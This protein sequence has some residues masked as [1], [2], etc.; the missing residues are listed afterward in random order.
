MSS[1]TLA[2]PSD[3]THT[4]PWR[5]AYHDLAG[6]VL[7][8]L[9]TRRHD[10]ARVR[11]HLGA[12]RSLI[13]AGGPGAGLA[14][15][16]ATLESLRLPHPHRVLRLDGGSRATPSSSMAGPLHSNVPTVYLVREDDLEPR[17]EAGPTQLDP[18]IASWRRGYLELVHLQPIPSQ[19]LERPIRQVTGAGVLNDLQVATIAMLA[20]GSPLIALDLALEAAEAPQHV[21]HQP[22]TAFT[23]SS[24]FGS[25]AAPRLRPRLDLLLQRPD[26][27]KLLSNIQDLARLGQVPESVAAMLVG[28]ADLALLSEFGV[29][30]H[31]GSGHDPYVAISHVN[32]VALRSYPAASDPEFRTQLSALRQAGYPTGETDLIAHTTDPDRTAATG[33]NQMLAAACVLNRLGEPAPARKLLESVPGSSVPTSPQAPDQALLRT[34]LLEGEHHAAAR[35]AHGLLLGNTSALHNA[36]LLYD[37]MVAVTW[38]PEIPAWF[39]QVIHGPLLRQDPAASIVLQNWA[40]EFGNKADTGALRQIAKDPSVHVIYRMMAMVSVISNQILD[41]SGQMGS[42]ARTRLVQ[43]LGLLWPLIDSVDA[44]LNRPGHTGR[45]DAYW[46]ATTAAIWAQLMAKID[47]PGVQQRLDAILLTATTGLGG[48]GWL[49]TFTAARLSGLAA[50]AR[51]DA[52]T[53]HADLALSTATVR[54]A[55]PPALTDDQ[56]FGPSVSA[57]LRRAEAAGQENEV[58]RLTVREDQVARLVLDGLSNKQIA[59]KLFISLRSVETHVLNSR[60]KLGAKDRGELRVLLQRGAGQGLGV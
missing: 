12:G 47:L 56:L 28:A 60:R 14:P 54:P 57:L 34:C 33:P 23:P 43:D 4:A 10:V 2:V 8:A 6:K 22:P 55:L 19:E 41:E 38:L 7:A 44:D 37:A 40:D 26:H 30:R 5:A 13:V 18:L 59:R 52:R 53:A 51:G 31:I 3:P 9:P 25:S 17:V 24:D 27:P 50:A 58:P 46:V 49:P 15:L 20:E 16:A 42:S 48:A 32:A 39:E 21:P 1:V 35:I 11:A 29:A 45:P 36:E